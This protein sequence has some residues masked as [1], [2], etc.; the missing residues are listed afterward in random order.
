MGR[1]GEPA[2]LYLKLWST[3]DY[4]FWTYQTSTSVCIGDCLQINKVILLLYPDAC[5]LYAYLTSSML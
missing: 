3:E 4:L 2:N 5:L 1:V